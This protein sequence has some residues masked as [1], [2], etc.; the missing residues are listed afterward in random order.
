MIRRTSAK[1]QPFPRTPDLDFSAEGP[2]IAG[3]CDAEA[4]SLPPSSGPVLGPPIPF[5]PE[6]LLANAPVLDDARSVEAFLRRMQDSD[7][8]AID[9]ESAGFYRYK[10]TVNLIQI[11]GRTCAALIDPQG[12]D[13]WTPFREFAASSQALWLFH[14]SDYD[15]AVLAR[16]LEVLVPRLFD[17]R[18]AAQFLGIGELGLSSLTERFLGFPLDKKL[19]RCDWSRRPLTPA[20]QKYALLDAVCLVPIVDRLRAELV[21]VGRLGWVEEECATVAAECRAARLP[22]PNPEAFRIK[23]SNG[24]PARSLAVLREVWQLRER[25][26]QAADRAPFMILNNQALLEIARQ[27]PRSM[28]GL[29]TLANVHAG[30]LARHGEALRQAIVQGLHVD[31]EADPVFAKRRDR[32]SVPPL[33]GWEGELVRQLRDAR[34]IVASRIGLPPSLLAGLPALV[35]LAQH[36]PMDGE[37]FA[38]VGGLRPWQTELLQADFVPILHQP[39]PTHQAKKRRRRGR[40]PRATPPVT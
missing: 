10:S 13:D 5:D 30:F 24:L 29:R 33:T 15:A 3:F 36:S 32:R 4:D 35:Q 19:Q 34:N 21:A 17:T 11:S 12:M 14:G 31:I 16:E 22:P 7:V 25:I 9:T 39:P 20:M 6:P 38:Q 40:R 8:V 18:I 26:A 2:T 1:P 28:A 37:S 23:G 27:A